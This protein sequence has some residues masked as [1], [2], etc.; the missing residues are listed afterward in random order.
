[1]TD[2]DAQ[3]AVTNAL[4]QYCRCVDDGRFDDLGAL[5]ETD[6]VLVIGDEPP[7]R[8]REAIVAA[9]AGRQTPE[10]RGAHMTS[11]ALVR[12][13]GACA[14]AESDYVF[15]VIRSDGRAVPAAIGRYHDELSRGPEGFWRFTRRQISFLGPPPPSSIQPPGDRS[16]P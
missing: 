8:G 4:A 2:A 3:L 16:A 9:I 1:M 10:R 14:R 15:Y 11:N 7:C 5:F 13:D 12:L 6:A